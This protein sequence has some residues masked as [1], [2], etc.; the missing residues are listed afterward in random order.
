MKPS[1]E[2]SMPLRRRSVFALAGLL[3]GC[4][5]GGG[6]GP[7]P[8][9][10][11]VAPG[12]VVPTISI[13][14]PA[15]FTFTA[16][17][18]LVVSAV[19]ADDVGVTSV[20]FQVD[21]A[22]VGPAQSAPPYTA[23][24][25]TALYASG[26][27]VIRARA[28]D[29]AG[30]RSPWAAITVQFGTRT[31]PNGFTRNE[32]FVTGLASATAFAQA[33]DGRLFIAQQGGALRVVKAGTLL[34]TSF[35]TLLSVDASGERG[36]LGVALHPNFASNGF[37][38]VYYTTTAGGAH[39]RISRFI[40]AGDVAVPGSESVLVELPPLSAATNHN[41]GAIHFGIDGKLYV[42]VGDN[43]NSDNAQSLSTPLGK[44][45]R[46]N[47]DGTIPNDNPFFATQSGLGRAVW[48]Y[49]LRNP[50]TFAVQPGSGRIHINDVGE[51]TW[52]EINFGVAGANYGWGRNSEG[53]DNVTAGITGPLF[54]YKHSNAAPPGS[55]PGGFFVGFAITGGTFYPASGMFPAPYRGGYF[56]A[57]LVSKFVGFID[58][59]ND[60]AAYAFGSVTGSPVDMLVAADGALLVLTQSGVVRFS[61]P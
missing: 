1:T 10:P 54:T 42:G 60:N 55:G 12:S 31:Q 20:E 39:N 34:A 53:P 52:E 28:A 48:A 21:G 47:D 13:T 17:G 19:A 61:T 56:F 14:A 24:I 9:N 5:G 43:A 44:L 16:S 59:Q 51:A 33:G 36:L 25:D 38:Y 40:A 46:L 18:T 6:S 37:V 11:S 27:H 22:A 57:D 3:A 26:Q 8:A 58:L 50:F 15:N 4:G 23:S 35:V 41:G 32:A 29:A 2:V 49:G 30:N 45:L 7:A